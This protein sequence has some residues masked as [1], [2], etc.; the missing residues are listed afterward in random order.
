[1][2]ISPIF[3]EQ[4]FHKKVFCTAFMCLQFGFVNF[5]QKDFAAKAAHKMLVKFDTR[6]QILA[7]DFPLL[8]TFLKVRCSMERK[9]P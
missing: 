4:L 8:F 2:S 1:V 9:Q 5:W 7:A 3:Y 6:W